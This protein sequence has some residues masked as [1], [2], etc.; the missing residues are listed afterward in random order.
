MAVLLCWPCCRLSPELLDPQ[1]LAGHEACLIDK[2]QEA[3]CLQQDRSSGASSSS[4]AR[5]QHSLALD[6]RCAVAAGLTPDVV[7][8]LLHAYAACGC[9]VQHQGLRRLCEQLAG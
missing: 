6:V 2:L 4:K 5:K 1:W 7:R 8:Q 9:A 3:G